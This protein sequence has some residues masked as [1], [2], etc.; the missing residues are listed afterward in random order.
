MKAEFKISFFTFCAWVFYS[1]NLESSVNAQTLGFGLNNADPIHIEASDG[2]EWH[3][4]KK[5]YIARGD[6][7]ARQGRVTVIADELL[8]YYR[9]TKTGSEE[10]YKINAN[11]N[12]SIESDTDKATSDKAIYDVVEGTLIMTGEQIRFTTPLDTIIARESL[13]Y[14]EKKN[15][16]I[17]QGDAIAIRAD[18]RLRADTLKAHFITNQDD[19]NS[20]KIDRI[21]AIGNVHLST[22]TDIVTAEYADYKVNAGLVSMS[23]SVKI[24]RGQTQLNGD[25]A[26]VN[27]NTGVSRLLTNVKGQKKSGARVRG[28]F[29]PSVLNKDNDLRRNK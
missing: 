18:K 28:I 13:E 26:E 22:A 19:D 27:L 21:N 25:R 1:A 14:Y 12:V 23:G 4:N 11:G 15:L 6:A 24:T 16:A 8:A 29:M 20:T 10:I 7:K 2:I 5:L 3:K 9:S 17:A